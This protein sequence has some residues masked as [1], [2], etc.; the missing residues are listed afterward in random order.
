MDIS[1][2]KKARKDKKKVDKKA[3]VDNFYVLK[4]DLFLNKMIEN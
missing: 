2:L 3:N 1:S 4:D